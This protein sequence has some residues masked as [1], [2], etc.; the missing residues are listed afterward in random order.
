VRDGI[1]FD[2]PALL[3]DVRALV[4]AQ[5]TAEAQATPR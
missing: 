2:A 1:V 5:K 3:E 4:A